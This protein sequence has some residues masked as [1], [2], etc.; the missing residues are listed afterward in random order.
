[1]DAGLLGECIIPT[2]RHAWKH[3]LLPRQEEDESTNQTSQFGHVIPC[4]ATV[5]AMGIESVEIRRQSK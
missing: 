1:M 2:L 4:G 3:L 5:H